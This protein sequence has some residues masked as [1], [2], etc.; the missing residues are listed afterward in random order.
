MIKDQNFK[1]LHKDLHNSNVKRYELA[2]K[3]HVY[4]KGSGRLCL[5]TCDE[6]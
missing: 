1:S 2:P 4:I 5:M 6:S 3:R